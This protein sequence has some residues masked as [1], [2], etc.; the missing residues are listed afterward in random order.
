[1][2]FW[3]LFALYMSSNT[4]ASVPWAIPFGDEQIKVL[5]NQAEDVLDWYDNMKDPVPIWYS[6]LAH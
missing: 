2:E 3:E 6:N 5:V 1:M 4:L